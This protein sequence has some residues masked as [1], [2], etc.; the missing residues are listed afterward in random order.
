MRALAVLTTIT[1][2][3]A[4]PALAQN[5]VIGGSS[6]VVVGD[7]PAARAGDV[8]TGGAIVEGSKDVFINGKPAAIGGSR[9]GCGGVVVGGGANVFINGKPMARSGDQAT[10]CQ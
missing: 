7:K 4:M 3:G 8:T 2:L 9:T 5:A 6:D 10:G 1:L